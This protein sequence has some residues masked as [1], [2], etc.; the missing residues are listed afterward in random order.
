M[1]GLLVLPALRKCQLGF[2]VS[3]YLL[4]RIC[5]SCPCSVISAPDGFLA[6]AEVCPGAGTAAKGPGSLP[7]SP[8][9]ACVRESL[10]R[11]HHWQHLSVSSCSDW[12]RATCGSESV[13]CLPLSCG[14]LLSGPV[15]NSCPVWS[16][17]RLWSEL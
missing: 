6:G 10:S 16:L 2:L 11:H 3:S 14:D 13:N 4:R 12:T 8:S 1:R 15:V 7:V 17:Q 9:S 5:P